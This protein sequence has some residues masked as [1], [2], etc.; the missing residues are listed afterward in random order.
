LKSHIGTYE[1]AGWI[2]AYQFVI[3][4]PSVLLNKWQRMHWAARSRYTIRWEWLVLNAIKRKPT[5]PLDVAWVHVERGSYGIPPDPDGLVGGLKPLLD[6]LTLPR[7]SKKH[8]LG[9]IVDD[10]PDHLKRL[11]AHSIKTRKGEGYT[12]ITIYRPRP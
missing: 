3:A 9:L 2:D 11:T 7:A 5:K 4:E 6:I 12:K 8:G 1:T 10:S